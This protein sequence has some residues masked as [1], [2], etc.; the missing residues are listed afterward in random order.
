MM[1][2]LGMNI[3]VD[4]GFT[5][6]EKMLNRYLISR[7]YDVGSAISKL[8]ETLNWRRCFGLQYLYSGQ[9]M[10]TMKAENLSGKLYVRGYDKEGNAVIYIRP[11]LENTYNHDGNI[12]HLVYNVER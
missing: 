3:K 2:K 8:E 10:E 1:L 5:I 11:K 6:D 7:S 12:K 9:W 4:D